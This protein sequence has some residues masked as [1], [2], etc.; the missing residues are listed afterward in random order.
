MKIG[1]LS[2]AARNALSGIDD[3]FRQVDDVA[4][5]VAAGIKH[6]NGE[7]S[8]DVSRALT[9]LPALKQQAAANAKVFDTAENL[10]SVLAS[11]PRR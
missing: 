3:V 11:K 9:K 10:M 8:A 2:S 5:Q 1:S 6:D 7:S 4:N